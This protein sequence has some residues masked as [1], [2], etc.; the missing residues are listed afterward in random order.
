MKSHV[1]NDLK[2]IVFVV[3]ILCVFS[4]TNLA[5]SKPC[6]CGKGNDNLG[7]VTCETSQRC[8]CLVEN[9]KVDGRC[10]PLPTYSSIQKEK[11][12]SQYLSEVLGRPVSVTE[13]KQDSRLQQA[14]ESGK[15]EENGKTYNF[16]AYKDVEASLSKNYL[17]RDKFLANENIFVSRWK[18]D[19]LDS[20]IMEH[21]K[22]PTN[23]NVSENFFLEL[24]NYSIQEKRFD[25]AIKILKLN[26]ELN[27][28]SEDAY[29]ELGKAYKLNAGIENSNEN[30]KK[31][32]EAFTRALKLSSIRSDAYLN[33]GE[34][35]ELKGDKE[36]AI[37]TYKKA[38]SLE[39]IDE[40]TKAMLSARINNLQSPLDK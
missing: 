21:K 14:L 7:T 34:A 31:A 17:P 38:L 8:S 3:A 32:I 36:K 24:G 15:Y 6:D 25:E 40:K 19:G 13:I 12:Q 11:R 9:S 35:Y 4:L 37:E 26:T 20:A 33:L 27:P 23:S 18:L 30:Y 28:N 16:T 22:N 29:F 1:K 10:R 39:S 5:Q 2:F